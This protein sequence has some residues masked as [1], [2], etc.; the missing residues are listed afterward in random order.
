MF[1]RILNVPGVRQLYARRFERAFASNWVGAFRGVYRS[2]N[3]ARLAAPSSKPLGYDNDASAQLY[4]DR[5]ETVQPADYPILLW[6]DRALRLGARS[7]FD[8]G[9][10]VGL[11]YYGYRKYLAYPEGFRWTVQDVPRVVAIGESI[12]A[13]HGV[14]AQLSFTQSLAEADGADFMLCSGSLQ[15][16][17]DKSLWGELSRMQRKPR[18]I[19]V[20]KLPLSK[21]EAFWTLQNVGTA[22]C[23]YQIFNEREFI[24]AVQ[25]QGYR[26]VDRW[27]NADCACELPLN[28]ERN[29]KWYSGMLFEVESLE[30]RRLISTPTNP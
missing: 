16:L 17:D 8:W 4:E 20:N 28:P 22:F 15:Y 1:E 30:P 2:F 13:K 21:G 25:Q 29:V 7:V 23:P 6:L 14:S 24:G 11:L 9:G 3:E 18:W 5:F 12:A 10:H 26:L 27:Y 19:A